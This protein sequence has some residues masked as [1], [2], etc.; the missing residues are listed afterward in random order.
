MQDV[1]EATG[2]ALTKDWTHDQ[3]GGHHPNDL[4]SRNC[5]YFYVYLLS[6][7][8]KGLGTWYLR[9]SVVLALD[10][11]LEAHQY[12]SPDISNKTF[13]TCVSVAWLQL[14]YILYF[15]SFFSWTPKKM[16]S[17]GTKRSLPEIYVQRPHEKHTWPL[18]SSTWFRNPLIY[19]ISHDFWEVLMFQ[20]VL[21]CCAMSLVSLQWV[22]VRPGRPSRCQR[23]ELAAPRSRLLRSTESSGVVTPAS[24]SCSENLILRGHAYLIK[25]HIKEQFKWL[26]WSHDLSAREQNVSPQ[27]ANISEG[28]DRCWW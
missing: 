25:W 7:P 13:V 2:H 20:T 5:L 28:N 6:R 18:L 16:S 22:P 3:W 1:R 9:T 26:D 8:R 10:F 27:K 24:S 17:S 19:L 11:C 15:L 12:L 21:E 14:F 23:T 4:R